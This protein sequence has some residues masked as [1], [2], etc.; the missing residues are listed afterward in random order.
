[1]I[2]KYLTV[3]SMNGV[4]VCYDAESGKVIWQER[5]GGNFSASPIAA[6]G[7]AYFQ[8]ED[9]S[10]SV[11]RPGPRLDVIARNKIDPEGDEIF[12]ASP[13]P[14]EGQLF[15]RSDRALYCVGRASQAAAAK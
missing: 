4:A 2:G 10:V 5:L 13:A 14:C 15:L 12:R 11:I 9:G 7:L 8:S 6:A 1:V 3:A